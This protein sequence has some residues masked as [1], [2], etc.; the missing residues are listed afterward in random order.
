MFRILIVDDSLI[1]LKIIS[2]LLGDKYEVST[3][4]SGQE[5]IL[6]ATETVPDLILLDILMPDMDGLEVCRFL[7]RQ[8]ATAEIPIIFITVVSEPKDIVRAFE[9]GGQDYI[10]KPFSALELCARMKTH[11]ELKQ[12][13]EELKTYARQ[14]EAKNLELKEALARL[15]ISA[16]TDFLTNLPNRRYMLQKIQEEIARIK[17][18]KS[19]MTLILLDVD[20]FKDINDS[21]GHDCGDAVLKGIADIMRRTVREQDIVTRWGGDEFLFLLPDTDFAGGQ[22]V[23]EKIRQAI[24]A[25]TVPYCGKL[26]SVSVS[27]GVAQYDVEL[28]ID[29][30]IKRADEALYRQKKQ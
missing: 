14:L 20:N 19:A 16:I 24:G 28:D 8:S 1:N 6:Q 3:A 30:N 22:V 12:S 2:G 29:A 17:R 27:F 4:S 23:G 7:K 9:A 5:A 11:L 21:V 25:S 26:F 15:E 18:A 10:T 13:R